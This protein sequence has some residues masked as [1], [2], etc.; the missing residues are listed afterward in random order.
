MEKRYL[1][2]SFD[3]RF[4]AKAIGAKWDPVVRKWW[5]PMSVP[6]DAVKQWKPEVKT[7]MGISA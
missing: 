2:V 3:D 4:K 6:L 7:H 5:V 1:Q